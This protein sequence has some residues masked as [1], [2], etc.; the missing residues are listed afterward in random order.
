LRGE[1][2]RIEE[3]EMD[4]DVFYTRR[5]RRRGSSDVK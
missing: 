1:E 4:V 3:K 5:R 2:K